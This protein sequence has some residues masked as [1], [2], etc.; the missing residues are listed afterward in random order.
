MLL[1]PPPPMFP[2]RP[3]HSLYDTRPHHAPR[4]PRTER[5]R[6][7][8]P[9]MYNQQKQQFVILTPRSQS[10]FPATPHAGPVNVS[11]AA[12]APNANASRTARRAPRSSPHAAATRHRTHRQPARTRER[13]TESVP[14]VRARARVCRSAQ[15]PSLTHGSA[16]ASARSAR[17]GPQPRASLCGMHAPASGPNRSRTGVR[18]FMGGTRGGA[19]GARGACGAVSVGALGAAAVASQRRGGGGCSG[20]SRAAAWRGGLTSRLGFL[21]LS[22]LGSCPPCCARA[23]AYTH[24]SRVGE[25]VRGVG[26]P[27]RT[28]RVFAPSEL[29]RRAPGCSG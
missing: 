14:T 13:T 25:S 18:L 19:G 28:Y 9:Q 21:P 15:K 20:A 6:H 3:R 29:Q 11:A 10:P 4:F 22:S 12:Q 2:N 24:M 1:P 16:S 23:R 26:R 7:E 27:L 8:L 5:E 17:R